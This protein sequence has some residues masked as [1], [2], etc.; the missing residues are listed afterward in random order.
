V[1]A[2]QRSV[3]LE[4]QRSQLNGQYAET[5]QEIASLERQRQVLDRSQSEPTE[6]EELTGRIG[7]LIETR[8]ALEEQRQLLN[9]KER[10]LTVT[11]PI[12]GRVVTWK[13]RDL[14]E[15][16]PVRRGQRLMEI[17]DP[18]SPWEL[19]IYVPE[20]KMGHVVQRLQELRAGD[21]EAQLE[22]SFILETHSDKRLVGKVHE[23]DT[24]AQVHGESGNTVRMVVAF[25]QE[26][27]KQLV[28]DPAN[29]LK[30]GA[31]VKAKILCGKRA[32]GYVWF[33]DLFEFVQS[34]IL[35]RL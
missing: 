19:E 8:L 12:D 10:L 4:E 15:N 6:L 21:P 25:E 9:E 17:A 5:L 23:I 30:V 24:I 11:S 20:A 33:S 2:R 31:D 32:I 22:V 16:R 13:V 18:S 1:L 35:F 34:R 27:L 7:Q 26:D 29:Q 28:P 14:I 3:E